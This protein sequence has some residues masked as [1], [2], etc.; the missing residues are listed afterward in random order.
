MPTTFDT[1]TTADLSGVFRPLWSLLDLLPVGARP[2]IA[3]AATITAAALI[4]STSRGRAAPA[5]AAT[6]GPG[7]VMS[8]EEALGHL[9]RVKAELKGRKGEATVAEVLARVELPALHDVVLRDSRGLTQVD[10]LVRLPG[11]IVVLETKAI[12]GVVLCQEDAKA[13]CCARDEGRPFGAA[14]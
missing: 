11:G 4:L 9:R 13:S 5:P 8:R 12:G 10:H 14:L 7:S 2:S 3:L 1:T 6:P